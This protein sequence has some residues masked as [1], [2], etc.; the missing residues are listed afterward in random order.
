MKCAHGVGYPVEGR[1]YEVGPWLCNPDGSNPN[2]HK[3][4]PDSWAQG[5]YADTTLSRIH[6]NPV[7]RE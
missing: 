6:H 7:G 3:C 1:N 4:E 2:C 5:I